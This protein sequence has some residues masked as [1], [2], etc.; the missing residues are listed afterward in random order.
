MPT[1][2]AASDSRKRAGVI[3]GKL[4]RKRSTT[5][6][7]RRLPGIRLEPWPST[8]KRSGAKGLAVPTHGDDAAGREQGKG[9]QKANGLHG[10]ISLRPMS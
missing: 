9:K 7:S 1:R 2:Q 5:D 3:A 10:R 4:A 8:G 6:V